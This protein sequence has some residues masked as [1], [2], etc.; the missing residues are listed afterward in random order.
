MVLYGHMNSSQIVLLSILAV[1]VILLLA[2]RINAALVFLSLC[3]GDVLIQF[4]SY[5]TSS[6][7]TT[8]GIN[9]GSETVKLGLL[10]LPVVLTT[11]FMIRTVHGWRLLLNLL[12]SAG[13]GLVAAFLIVPLL[14]PGVAGNITHASMWRQIKTAQ[15]LIIGLSAL[16]SLLVLWLQ[17]PKSGE[18]KYRKKSK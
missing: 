2:L 11:I 18:S 7:L 1:P 3:L 5:D 8:I 13:V 17:R 16:V 14:P 9:L 15:D 10:T 6:L 12:P 4:V